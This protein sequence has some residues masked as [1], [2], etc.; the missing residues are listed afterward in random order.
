[1]QFMNSTAIKFTA[2]IFT[3]IIGLSVACCGSFVF[4]KFILAKE[5]QKLE[6]LN[7][8]VEIHML[9][10]FGKDYR[11]IRSI[12]VRDAMTNQTN[13]FVKYLTKDLSG[14]TRISDVELVFDHELKLLMYFTNVSE[15]GKVF[16]D[17]FKYNK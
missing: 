14:R 16:T 13:V 1:M 5:T 8:N 12:F 10:I 15:N 9:K 17:V 3:V 4:Y 2:I 7:Q 11:R 6:K